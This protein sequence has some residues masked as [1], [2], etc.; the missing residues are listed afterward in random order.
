M[1]FGIEIA[2]I[3]C[4]WFLVDLEL[5]LVR[6]VLEP[7]KSHVYGFRSF[8]FEFSVYETYGRCVVHLNR[9]RWLGVIQELEGVAHR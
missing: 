3:L 4:A 8:L 7:V 5:A 6:S 9:G 1:F 2:K